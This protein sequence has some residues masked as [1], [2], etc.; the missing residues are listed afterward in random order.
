ME[1]SYRFKSGREETKL[2]KLLGW[3]FALRSN[4]MIECG[5]VA[6]VDYGSPDSE[7]VALCLWAAEPDDT[8][9]QRVAS[10]FETVPGETKLP[11]MCAG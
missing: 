3:P 10:F 2:T 7:A 9:I 11:K 1:R 8:L 4:R 5:F 6:R